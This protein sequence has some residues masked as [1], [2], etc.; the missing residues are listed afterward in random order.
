MKEKHL[1][2]REDKEKI[3]KQKKKERKEKFDG[4]EEKL[5]KQKRFEDQE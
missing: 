5:G 3:I 1:Q 4:K 2:G